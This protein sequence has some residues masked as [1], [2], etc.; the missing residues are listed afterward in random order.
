MK[1]TPFFHDELA[2]GAKMTNQQGWEMPTDFGDPSA[3]HLAVRN[4]VGTFNWASTGEIEVSGPGAL[5]LI[6]RVIVNDASE[7][8]V[9]RVLYSTMCHP[10]G[11]IFSDITVY[12]MAESRYWVMTAWGS[13]RDNQRPE[14]DSLIQHAGGLDVTVTD[15]S[16]S[17]A[18]LAVQGPCSRDVVAK[19]ASPGVD[20]LPYMDWMNATIAGIPRGMISRTGYTGELGYELIVPSEYGHELW[21]AVMGA[22]LEYGIRPAGTTA[23]FSLRMEKG[24]IARFDILDHVTPYEARLGWTVKLGKDDFVGREAL[25]KQKEQG[26]SRQLVTIAMQ[27]ECLPAG[28]CAVLRDGRVV[29]RVTS[30]AFGHSMGSPLGLAV[31][32]IDSAQ[33]GTALT[34]ES[35]GGLH[36]AQVVPRPYYDPKGLRLRA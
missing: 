32:A 24:Y 2:A 30:S 35:E 13:N 5:A 16:S 36:P 4:G 15:F 34:V 9:G 27:D 20:E 31:V 7:M 28:G 29:G 6:Q 17:I 19:L 21:E 26:A 25:L 8:P 23:A 3:E 11:S 12:R 1:R 22:G 33:P 10:D 18:I 14:Y